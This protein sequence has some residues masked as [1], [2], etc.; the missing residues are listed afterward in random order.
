MLI[1]QVSL[2]DRIAAGFTRLWKIIR[3]LVAPR[4]ATCGRGMLDYGP[5]ARDDCPTP[6]M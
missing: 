4:C 1:V 2:L 5:C 6:W 3:S